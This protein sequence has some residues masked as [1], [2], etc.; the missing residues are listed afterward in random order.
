MALR[1]KSIRLSNCDGQ[2]SAFKRPGERYSSTTVKKDHIFGGGFVMVRCGINIGEITELVSIPVR[3]NAAEQVDLVLVE[4]V[5]P[6]VFYITSYF[7]L[8]PDNAK[9]HTVTPTLEF[10]QEL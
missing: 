3:L 1:T 6:A 4:H 8:K 7:V 10:M 5:V 2:V 9:L